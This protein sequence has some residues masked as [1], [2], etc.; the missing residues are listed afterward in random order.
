MLLLLV[1][2]A[3]LWLGWRVDRAR[4]QRLAIAEIKKYHGY[5]VFNY[6]YAGRKL[7]PDAQPM[8]PR[9]LRRN[10]GDEYFREVTRVVYV[11]EPP[12]DATLAPL[13]DLGTIEELSFLTRGH[14]SGG[15]ARSLR[16]PEKL[17]ET[18]LARLEG[19][20]S[21]RRLEFCGM[22]LNGS[23]LRSCRQSTQLEELTII[24]P[25]D[26]DVGIS[27]EDIPPLEAMPRLRFLSLWCRGITGSCL[28]PLRGSRSLEELQFYGS[29]LSLAGFENIGAITNLK[30]L[31][32]TEVGFTDNSLA[33]LRSLT[34]LTTL[35]L[36]AD[37]SKISDTGL[38][39]LGGM[40][41]LECLHLTG[42]KIT[43][44]GMES[45]KDMKQ[46][47][48]L[49]LGSTEVDDAGL[50]VVGGLPSLEEL[51][52]RNTKV[53]DAGLAHLKGLKN[54]RTV[55]VDETAITPKAVDELMEAIARLN[56]GP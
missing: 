28:K 13:A 52:L 29:P 8:G 47:K 9:W 40:T 23:M 21:L 53:T 42:S 6:E 56:D 16:G 17:T 46:L 22:K 50:K 20:T 54:L 18:G 27:D 41:R 15:S 34:R 39:H 2:V 14:Q 5:V 49:W 11:D 37:D 12:S 51:D 35:T 44:R 19:L 30:T 38:V 33:A 55:A 48:R 24:E 45:L 43:G 32:F 4:R 1:L 26:T 25:R 36:D 10:L 7:I 31:R 3:G